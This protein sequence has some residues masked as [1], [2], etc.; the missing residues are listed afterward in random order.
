MAFTRPPQIRRAPLAVLGL[1]LYLVSL[2]GCEQVT[3]KHYRD[4]VCRQYVGLS[5]PSSWE[6]RGE[7]PRAPPTFWRAPRWSE[8]SRVR[9]RMYNITE[10]A[11]DDQIDRAT[12]IP[13]SSELARVLAA[14]H[15]KLPSGEMRT[16]PLQ[17]G[18]LSGTRVT[19][20]GSR[21]VMAAFEVGTC[22]FVVVLPD[23]DRAE[24][25]AALSSLQ[26]GPT[27]ASVA[28]E[29]PLHRLGAWVWQAKGPNLRPWVLILVALGLT[30][31]PGAWSAWRVHPAAAEAGAFGF[32]EGKRMFRVVFG[33]LLAL[34]GV[35]VLVLGGA[36]L[37]DLF[38][39]NELNPAPNNPFP[40]R[41]SRWPS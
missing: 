27:F 7:R 16:E 32:E 12:G 40:V 34:E 9:M 21:L 24:A 29:H 1:L 19:W 11:L 38:M 13:G 23:A 22:H 18:Q 15:A 8:G 14:T 41:W 36:L 39:G 30:L 6:R 5:V 28:S 4:E 2:A 20:P 33:T 37:A 10:R 3:G 31:G 35:L 26:L 25:E 17:A